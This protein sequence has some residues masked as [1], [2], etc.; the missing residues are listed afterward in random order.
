MRG[1]I[2]AR[3]Q[4]DSAATYSRKIVATDGALDWQQ[5]AETLWRRI[6]AYNPW[7]GCYTLWRGKRLKIHVATVAAGAA[8]APAGTVVPLGDGRKNV[9]VVT[10]GGVLKLEIVQLEGKRPVPADEFIRG[11]SDFMNATLIS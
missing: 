4:D 8:T 3:V 2:D 10:G 11:Q 6:R 7:P 1:E 5:P 9:G